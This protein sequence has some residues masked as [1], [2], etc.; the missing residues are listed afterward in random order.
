MHS[1][2][3]GVCSSQK[4]RNV[5]TLHTHLW[6]HCLLASYPVTSRRALFS[7]LRLGNEY[8]HIFFRVALLQHDHIFPRSFDPF[9]NRISLSLLRERFVPS[10][11][12]PRLL[13]SGVR[14]YIFF[15]WGS[16]KPHNEVDLSFPRDPR[17][18]N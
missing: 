17:V 3:I 18:D 6:I 16:S 1:R 11:F 15:R 5:R 10:R 14:K 2:L 9:P 4:N 12:S 8:V 13:Y 7:F